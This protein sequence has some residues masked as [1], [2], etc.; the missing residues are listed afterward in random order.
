LSDIWVW[1]LGSKIRDPEVKKAPDPGSGFAKLVSKHMLKICRG[2][3]GDQPIQYYGFLDNVCS[4]VEF[5]DCSCGPQV[6]GTPE[7]N[8]LNIGEKVV[9]V[10]FMKIQLLNLMLQAFSS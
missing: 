4:A 6:M 10:T 7:A 1:D 2:P 5:R 3:P 8:S 9:K